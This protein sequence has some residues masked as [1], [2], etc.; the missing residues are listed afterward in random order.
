[1]LSKPKRNINICGRSDVLSY[2]TKIISKI[3]QQINDLLIIHDFVFSGPAILTPRMTS[4]LPFFQKYHLFYWQIFTLATVRFRCWN[5]QYW[6]PIKS[7]MV[8][9]QGDF[10]PCAP[11]KSK[12]TAKNLSF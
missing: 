12:T 5:F 11:F 10:G 4:E 6:T 8:N 2:I 9:K 1:M 3:N 7:K